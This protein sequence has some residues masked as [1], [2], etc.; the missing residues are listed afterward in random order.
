MNLSQLVPISTVAET[1]S[2]KAERGLGPREIKEALSIQS[3]AQPASFFIH[4]LGE[5]RGIKRHSN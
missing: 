3:P 4:R 2:S 1:L 5:I